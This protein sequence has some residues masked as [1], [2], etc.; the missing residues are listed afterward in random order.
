EL[1]V[2]LEVPERLTSGEKAAIGG[3]AEFAPGHQVRLANDLSLREIPKDDAAGVAPCK[4]IAKLVALDGNPDRRALPAHRELFAV[5]G[6]QEMGDGESVF[7]PEG[8]LPCLRVPDVNDL[9][10]ADG[11]LLAVA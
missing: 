4:G 10:D 11:E 5:A 9:A 7:E 1:G 2:L 6:E 8:F 3:L